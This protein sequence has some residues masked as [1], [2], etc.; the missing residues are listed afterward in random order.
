MLLDGL[1]CTGIDLKI[2]WNAENKYKT[3][4]YL[5]D[6]SY[7]FNISLNQEEIEKLITQCNQGQGT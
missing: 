1:H 7:I 2:I 3:R 4:R 5:E 6:A